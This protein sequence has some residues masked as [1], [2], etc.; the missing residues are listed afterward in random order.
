[1]D[2]R[3][4]KR[5]KI[6]M[7]N[8]NKR[9]KELINHNLLNRNDKRVHLIKNINFIHRDNNPN[10]SLLSCHLT[11]Y[12]YELLQQL[13]KQKAPV[14]NNIKDDLLSTL[15]L[16]HE[17]SDNLNI[18]LVH[19][20][21]INMTP[22]GTLLLATINPT[23]RDSVVIEIAALKES[24][25]TKIEKSWSNRCFYCCIWLLITPFILCF[26]VIL[27]ISLLFFVSSI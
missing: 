17:F 22:V 23:S 3:K 1:M 21:V 20:I 15:E 26:A 9:I 2:N 7:N 5:V 18:T 14:N 4:E 27:I 12:S 16:L 8:Q 10:T 11:C 24:L 25:S 19:S 13:I 6:Q